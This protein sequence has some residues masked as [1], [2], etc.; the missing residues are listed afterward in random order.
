VTSD[1]YQQLLVDGVISSSLSNTLFIV[2]DDSQ[3]NAM[4]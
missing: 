2:N 1:K 3:I 4:G